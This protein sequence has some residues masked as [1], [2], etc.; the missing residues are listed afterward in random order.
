[1]PYEPPPELAA[2][3]LAEVAD[4]VATRKLP[5]VAEWTPEA[6]GDSEMRIAADGRWFHQDGEIRRPAMVRAFASLLTRDEAGQHWLVTPM[7]KLSIEVED[8]AFIA[9]DVKREGDALAFRLNTDDLVIA[10]PEHP[11]TAEGDAET[12]ALYV[13]VRNGTRARLN[14]ST[15]AQ[16][17]EIALE[18][19]DLS[20]GSKGVRF[21]LV[22]A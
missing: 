17:V 4:L 16:L 15:Y 22:P 20:V 5:P 13:A 2:L 8:A 1:M 21:P 12:P 19:D 10:G 11:I 9:I 3:S 7:Q 6:Q 14:R 18:G